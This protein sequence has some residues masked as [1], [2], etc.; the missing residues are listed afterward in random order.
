MLSLKLFSS[1]VNWPVLAQD[2]MIKVS[3]SLLSVKCEMKRTASCCSDSNL[4]TTGG[5]TVLCLEVGI[6]I[7]WFLSIFNECGPGKIFSI[8]QNFWVSV[9]K[10]MARALLSW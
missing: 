4:N 7:P 9:G 8:L 6:P 1:N 10:E 5:K 2:T 3:I